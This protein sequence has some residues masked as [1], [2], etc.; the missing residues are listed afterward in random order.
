MKHILCGVVLLVSTVAIAQ[1]GPAQPQ[2][3]QQPP[4]TPPTF[5]NDQQTP[6]AMPPDQNEPAPVPESSSAAQ[7]EQQIRQQL[8]SEPKLAGM[9]LRAEVDEASIVISGTVETAEQ[10]D[11]ALEIARSHAGDRNVVDKIKITRQT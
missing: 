1:M 5:P 10:H 7:I 3:G 11:L 6:R 9:N 4:S 8:N 2:P